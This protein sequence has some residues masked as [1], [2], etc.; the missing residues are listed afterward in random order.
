MTF[1]IDDVLEVLQIVKECKDTE[2]HI[3]TGE[4]K[5]SLSK[6]KVS[7][8]GIGF[9]NPG[10]VTQEAG[11]I[12]TATAVKPTA[13]AM[14]PTVEPKQ[15]S[16]NEAVAPQADINSEAASEEGLVS[17]KADVNSVFYRRPSPE[18]PSFVEVGDEV[19]EE[20]VVCLLEVMKCF[21]QVMAGTRG[22]IEKI[23]VE[24][25]SLVEE[26]TVLFLIRPE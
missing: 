16:Q 5:L 19:T 1:N 9:I 2:I 18:E 4:M 10:V 11:S 23:C 26:G 21:R 15:E 3:D 20:S 22:R 24:S 14:T 17:I 25:S 7:G 13:V 6:G 12:A 8:G